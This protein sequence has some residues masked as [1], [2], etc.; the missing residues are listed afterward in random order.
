[1]TLLSVRIYRTFLS[2]ASFLGFIPE[3]KNKKC[4]GYVYNILNILIATFLCIYYGWY[5]WLL[6]FEKIK[7]SKK[8]II[9]L[10]RLNELVFMIACCLIRLIY[11]KQWM[12]LVSN[13]EY[14]IRTLQY[15]K[16]N[17]IKEGLE[18]LVTG[19][20]IISC[21]LLRIVSMFIFT[22]NC[23]NLPILFSYIVER[24]WYIVV[25]VIICGILDIITLTNI[26]LTKSL[27]NTINE[28]YAFGKNDHDVMYVIFNTRK[29]LGHITLALYY[30]NQIF[31][32]P[33]LCI[34]IDTAFSIITPIIF[35]L[36]EDFAT[37]K[38]FIRFLR[39]GFLLVSIQ[40]CV[41]C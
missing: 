34:Y 24:S 12:R 17:H 10:T 9:I 33:I 20:F 29:A 40:K 19:L 1:M 3:S 16:I 23:L 22:G 2:I 4:L 39:S 11:R 28:Y 31:A 5:F 7:P 15:S 6:N 26:Y 30:F 41:L 21:T 18:T 36:N 38:H 32:W 27:K 35:A 13:L 14:L 8:I 37:T 25:F